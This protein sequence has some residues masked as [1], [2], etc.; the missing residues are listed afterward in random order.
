MT[1]GSEADCAAIID[2]AVQEHTTKG[3]SYL[4]EKL[5][6]KTEGADKCERLEE[7]VWRPKPQAYVVT[8]VGTVLTATMLYAGQ[9]R[10]IVFR[11]AD[12]TTYDPDKPDKTEYSPTSLRRVAAFGQS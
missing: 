11:A 2:A 6:E 8:R 3:T 1:A 10:A 9:N 4:T 12:D 5:C 7:K